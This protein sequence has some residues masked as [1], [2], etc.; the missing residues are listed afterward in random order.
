L[1][2]LILIV[3]IIFTAHSYAFGDKEYNK[4]YD[5]SRDPFNDFS[6]AQSDAIKKDNLI[7]I[8]V[9]GDWCIWCHKL[10]LFVIKSK[11]IGK[12]LDETFTVMKVNVSDEN[13]NEKFISQLPEIQGYPFFVIVD[14]TGAIVGVQ[15]TGSLE[16]GG[17]YSPAKFRDFIEHWR[18]NK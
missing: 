3:S 8:I 12:L 2:H 11:E 1:K 9:G 10:G 16:Q 4:A 13:D 7:L 14:K 5:P 18:A 17:T 15:D 6:V